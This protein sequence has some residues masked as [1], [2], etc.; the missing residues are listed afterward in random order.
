[1]LS[2]N[3]QEKQVFLK[4][5][6]QADGQVL[7][8]YI[9]KIITEVTSIDNLSSDIIVNMQNVK[10]ILNS[11]LLEHLTESKVEEFEEDSYE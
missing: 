1:M 11:Q 4:L 8:E 3:E 6:R 9:K 7:K 5:S 2:L 10:S